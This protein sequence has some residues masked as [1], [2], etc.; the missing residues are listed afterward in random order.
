[1]KIGT[2]N[3][4]DVRYRIVDSILKINR[5]DWDSVFGNIPE[6]YDFYHALEKSNLKEF[7][8]YYL[9]LYRNENI[10]S[11]APLFVADLYLDIVLKG[12]AKKIV[13]SIRRF[14]PRFF[15]LKTL[16]CG[17][18]FGENGV[19]GIRKDFKDTSALIHQLA[20][21]M[22]RF[23]RENKIPFIVFKDFLKDDS[24]SLHFL[25]EKGFFKIESFPSVRMELNFNSL[26][27]YFQSLSYSTRKDLR[28]KIKEAYS[29]GHL[30]VKTVE[31]VED[32]IEDI[33]RLYLN[34]YHASKIKF[35]FLTKD[36]FIHVSKELKPHTQYFLYYVGDRLCAFNLCFVYDDLLIDKFIGFD[37]EIAHQYSLYFVSWYFNIEWCLKHSIHFYQPGQTDYETKIKL[38]GSL[39]PLY[40]Y[41][42]HN[43]FLFNLI[44]KLLAIWLLK[45]NSSE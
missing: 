15:V 13:H 27:Q 38:G 7:S 43:N 12:M 20:E 6:G 5:G 29:L 25:K 32:I 26:E 17:S 33:Y 34:T 28:R 19:L 39:V 37:Y 41:F 9:I 11:I 21:V 35:E 31:S 36:F 10:L 4:S 24:S 44:I 40:S 16:F 42:K 8:F 18:P 30:K 1:M 23:S 22:G 2:K 3:M 14:I 45:P